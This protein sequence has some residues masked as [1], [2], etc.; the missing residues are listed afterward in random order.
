MQEEVMRLLADAGIGVS[1]SARDYRPSVSLDGFETKM[2]K[3]RAI[4]EMLEAGAR[5]LGFAG[6]DWVAE[7]GADLIELLDTGLNPV[8]LVAAAPESILQDGELPDRP[9][10]IASEYAGITQRWIERKGLDATVLRSYGATEVLPPEDADCIVDNSASGSTL[11]SNNLRV[12]DELM[13]SSTRLYSTRSAMECPRKRP[14]I[15]RFVMVVGAVLAA[16]R[17]VMVEL[18]VSAEA[19][20]AVVAILPCMREPTVSPLRSSRGFAVKAA[21]LRQELASVIPAIKQRGGTDIIV[22]TPEQI[23]P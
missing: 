8:R 5:D 15:E 1:A 13:T 9:L 22:T 10:I 17:R 6:A 23:V 18:N 2:L 19:L 4:V 14:A 16:R 21:V 20:D 3:P 7:Q 11:A 12:I